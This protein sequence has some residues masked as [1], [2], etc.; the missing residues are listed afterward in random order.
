MRRFIGE[1]GEGYDELI[2]GNKEYIDENGIHTQL[3]IDEIDLSVRVPHS[4]ETEKDAACEHKCAK[5]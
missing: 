1:Y 3:T 2:I 4:S 5:M